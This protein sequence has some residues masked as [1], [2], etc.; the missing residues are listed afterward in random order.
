M[1]MAN[2][3]FFWQKYL[4]KA[5]KCTRICCNQGGKYEKE[6]KDRKESI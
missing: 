5:Y 6:S 3:H 1:I 2:S 4:T